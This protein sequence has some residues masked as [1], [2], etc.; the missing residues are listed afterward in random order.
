MELPCFYLKNIWNLY[1]LLHILAMTTSKWDLLEQ[2]NDEKQ[3]EEMD[4]DIDGQ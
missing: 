3:E 2:E 1:I 4:E